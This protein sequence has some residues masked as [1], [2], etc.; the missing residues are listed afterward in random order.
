MYAISTDAAPKTFGPF[1]QGTSAARFV[2]V[3]AQQPVDAATG[4]LV[5]GDVSAQAKQCL[6]NVSG[7]LANLELT[8]AD[9][10]KVTILLADISEVD[11]VY[12][13]CD[14]VFDV[15]RPACTVAAVSALPNGASI[16]IEAIACR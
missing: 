9:V 14:E 3:S 4:K 8:L 1:S 6:K 12:D 15:P 5:E 7:V 10:T 11:A 2:F 16:T 13:A